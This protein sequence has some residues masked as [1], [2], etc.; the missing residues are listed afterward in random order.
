M[1]DKMDS[2]GN[3]LPDSLRISTIGKFIRTTSLD[4]LPQLFNVIKGDMSLIGPRPFSRLHT[5]LF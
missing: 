2:E 4:E 1:T 3:L 5:S